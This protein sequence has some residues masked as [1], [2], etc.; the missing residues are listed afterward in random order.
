M[1]HNRCCCVGVGAART[2]RLGQHMGTGGSWKVLEAPAKTTK[3]TAKTWPC[4]SGTCGDKKKLTSDQ[5]AFSCYCHCLVSKC[6]LG[7]IAETPV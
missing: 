1:E 4:A 7:N 5:S 3:T 2:A 6:T